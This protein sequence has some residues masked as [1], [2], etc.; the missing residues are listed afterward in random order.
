M[1]S[2]PV[3]NA[4]DQLERYPRDHDREHADAVALGESCRQLGD[5][6]EQRAGEWVFPG[7]QQRPA[8][9]VETAQ[10]AQLE[11]QLAVAYTDLG[12]ATFVLAHH[13]ALTA[14]PLASRIQYI[15]Q[16]KNHLAALA[17]SHTPPAS[18]YL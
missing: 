3:Q 9:A 4:I 15:K 5:A 6:P 18:P 12:A 8:G 11:Q 13:G 7:A 16:L 14:P 10:A 2:L 1:T 17:C